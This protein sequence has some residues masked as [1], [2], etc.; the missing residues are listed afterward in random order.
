MNLSKTLKKDIILVV[1][2]D[3]IQRLLI[4]ESLDTHYYE[5]YQA[6]NGQEALEL[7]KIHKPILVILDVYMPIM[8]G[9]ETC[10]AIRQEEDGHYT[11][12]LIAT[13]LE[14]DQSIN[15]AYEVGATDFIAKPI[16]WTILQYRVRYSI[17][18]TKNI[19]SLDSSQQKNQ[20]I[21]SALPDI[22]ICFDK[23]GVCLDYHF[24]KAQGLELGWEVG[25]PLSEFFP[26][27]ITNLFKDNMHKLFESKLSRS[28]EYYI[29]EVNNKKYYETRLVLNGNHALAIIRDITEHK[30]SEQKLK[31]IAYFDQLT[32]L[33]NSLHIK[34]KIQDTLKK[35]KIQTDSCPKKKQQPFSVIF[36]DLDRFKHINDTYGHSVGDQ[37][38]QMVVTRLTQCF[39]NCPFLKDL[40]RN[41]VDMFSRFSGD[42]F[43]ILL[44]DDDPINTS[45]KLAHKIIEY[46]S[47]PFKIDNKELYVTPSIGI[48]I[49]PQD[50]EDVDSLLKNADSAVHHSKHDGRNTFTFYTDK[51]N[52]NAHDRIILESELRKA[53]DSNQFVMHYQPQVDVKNNRVI[54]AEALIRWQHPEKGIISPIEFIPIAEEI[55]LIAEIGQW[56]LEETCMQM[57]TWLKNGIPLK[58]MA[59]NLSAKQFRDKDLV[60]SIEEIL[61]KS[62]LPPHYLELELTESMMMYEEDKAIQTL[63]D[64]KRLGLKLAIDDFG[65]GYSSLSYLKNFPIDY[66]KI[67]K[68][69]IVNLNKDPIDVKIVNAIITMAHALQLEVIAEGV[70]IQEHF[71]KLAEQNCDI[72]Q[73]YLF[74]K[75]LGVADF[76]H[77]YEQYRQQ[78]HSEDSD[79]N[80]R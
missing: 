55:G 44:I 10:Q 17:R 6:E 60:G 67:D 7:F 37:I 71:E 56:I 31:H 74:S 21:L 36:I 34:E 48:S 13:S 8:D 54:G 64:L 25:K 78:Y 47:S 28:F 19:D 12:I 24:P 75:P 70:E 57:Q 73:G 79:Q 18:G 80:I 11:A 51:M 27:M 39:N 2:D 33:P 43:V 49:Y 3:P 53:L 22:M 62:N 59:I 16:N 69:F 72:I 23:N 40:G 66:L 20:A 30:V 38:L 45:S 9:F 42:E 32:K 26:I 1:D 77:F 35:I 63:H 65:T 52:E 61:R 76:E 5:I 29:S 50:G 14:D 41:K 46:L 68:A 15:R 58:S 4:T